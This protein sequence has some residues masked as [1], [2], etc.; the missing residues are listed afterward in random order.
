[1]NTWSLPIART[2]SGIED[3]TGNSPVHTRH[4]WMRI[5]PAL[6]V[7]ALAGLASANITERR[8]NQYLAARTKVRIDE[9]WKVLVGSNPAGAQNTNF[10]DASWANINVPHDM[11]A[12]LM[13]VGNN[14]IDPGQ[15][16]WY[17]KH[18]TAPAGSSG[19][20]VIIQF[21]GVYHDAVVY[22]N[23]TQVASQRY[24]YVSFNAD[25]TKYLNQTGDN[26]LAVWVDNLTVRRSR[27]YSGTGIFRHVWMITTDPVHVK[28]WGTAITTPGASASKST[29]NINTEV[30]NETSASV[31]RTLVTVLCD[32]AGKRIDSISTPITVA[33][34]ATTKF[35]QSIDVASPKL[36]APNNPYVYNAYTKILNGTA[37]VDDYVSPFGIRNITYNTS[38]FFINGVFTKMKG[39]CIH[40][41]MVPG[42]AVA[43]E[44][45]W[46]R[47]IKELQASGSNSIRT[48]HAPMAPEFYDLC[49]KMGMLVMDEWCDKWKN[50][51]V[52]SFYQDWDKVWKADLTAFL[53]RDRN[54]PSIYMWSY[55][56]E[57]S[58]ADAGGVVS[59]YEYDYSAMIVPFAKSI[60]N[61]RPY[62][63]AVA[64]GLK[65]DPPG[66]AKLQN[67]QDVVGVNYTNGSYG[68]IIN[69]NSKV[70]LIGTEQFPYGNS[71]NDCK[72]RNQV[73]GEHIWTGMDYLG[74]QSPFGFKSGFIDAC[75]FR[76]TWFYWQKSLMGASPVVKLGVGNPSGYAWT[77]PDLSE[78]WN[79]SGSK[80]VVVYT[81]CQNVDLYLNGTKVGSKA[82]P[83]LTSQFTVNWASGTLK[84]VGSNNGQQVAVDSLVTTGAPAKIVLKTDRTTIYAD[85][86]DLSNVEAY[87]TDAAGRH[88]WSAKNNLSYTISG[89]GRSFGIGTGYMNQPSPIV[90]SSRPAWEGR[91]YIPVQSTPTPGTITV[92]VSSNGLTTGTLTLTTV[93]QPAPGT[94]AGVVSR[95]ARG[96]TV[97][98]LRKSGAHAIEMGY[99][100]D[101]SGPVRISVLTP[102]GRE[103]A[104]FDQGVQKAGSHTW[105]WNKVPGERA[106]LVRVKTEGSS[107]SRV[108]AVP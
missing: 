51:M 17:R 2:D 97:S 52:R 108:V 81:N 89:A 75:A 94:P 46:A 43:P 5:L 15:K 85:G 22:I 101:K 16:G 27:W 67:Y 14:G 69:V 28:N 79:E 6:A 38:G 102:E 39:V 25:I 103:V 77:T 54:H 1:M 32:S 104:S 11:S 84:V 24:G 57:V 7:L 3:R 105:A 19:K 91:A 66:Y 61:S 37:L 8:E 64:N 47:V 26:V 30:T 10:N 41:T 76:K 95:A 56:N 78:S 98:F 106:Y 83:G 31:S 53:E 58:E 107:S 74:E 35:A 33:A 70:L 90:A 62:T 71:W 40:H 48:A 29:V 65:A 86:D 72:N 68:N 63:H 80:N 18:F 21:D 4:D 49:D 73:Y 60:D 12:V 99:Q 92:T 34:G 9:G 44:Q 23:G 96:T 13:G 93:P 87:V 20:K 82:N 50:M 59:Q 36:W 55:G 88:V 100:I 45:Y 42:G